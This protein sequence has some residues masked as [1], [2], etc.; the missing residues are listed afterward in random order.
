MEIKLEII[1]ITEQ[2]QSPTETEHAY[3]T[4]ANK[5]T[6]KLKICSVLDLLPD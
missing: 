3:F 4:M 1:K 6:E 2:L 5:K